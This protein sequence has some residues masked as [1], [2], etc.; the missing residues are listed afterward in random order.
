M[1]WCVATKQHRVGDS[2]HDT[3][4]GLENVGQA[5]TRCVCVFNGDRVK[6]GA[7]GPRRSNQCEY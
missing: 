2:L 5:S 7:D 4:H 6:M 1:S 3:G